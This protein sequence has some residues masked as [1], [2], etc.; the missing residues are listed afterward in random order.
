ML[1]SVSNVVLVQDIG[2]D[3]SGVLLG[4]TNTAAAI[5]GIVGVLL[6]GAILQSNPLAWNV[7]FYI[8]VGFY[9]FGSFVFNTFATTK[10]VF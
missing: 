1:F 4:I 2:P 10:R 6:T 3:I 7:V 8:T 5:P 9:V